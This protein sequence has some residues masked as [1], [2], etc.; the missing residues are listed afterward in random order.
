MEYIRVPRLPRAGHR[1][2]LRIRKLR[3]DFLYDNGVVEISL[4]PVRTGETSI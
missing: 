4:L 3:A 1:V 2:T